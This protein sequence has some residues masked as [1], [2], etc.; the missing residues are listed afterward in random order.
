MTRSAT[1]D[2]GGVGISAVIRGW[3]AADCALVLLP[4]LYWPVASGSR[5]VG[6]PTVLAY[7]FG[8]SVFIAASIVCAYGLGRTSPSERR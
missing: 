5:I 1:Y 6:V 2:E 7:L 4:A 8:T 3:F